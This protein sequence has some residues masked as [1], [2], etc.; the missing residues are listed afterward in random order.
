[1]ICLVRLGLDGGNVW[2]DSVEDMFKKVRSKKKKKV[3]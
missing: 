3:Q 2:R 1:M